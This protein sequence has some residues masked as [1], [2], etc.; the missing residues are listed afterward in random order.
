MAADW[1]RRHRRGIDPGGDQG[2]PFAIA[3]FE[4]TEFTLPAR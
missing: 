3:S 1:R 4:G 2:G